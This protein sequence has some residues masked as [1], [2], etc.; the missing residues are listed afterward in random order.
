M[1]IEEYHTVHEIK[2]IETYALKGKS[3]TIGITS[4]AAIY[5]SIDV[6]RGLIRRCADI[7]VVMSQEAAK[8]ISPIL[9]EWACG[10]R[11]LHEISGMVEHI[12]LAKLCDSMAIVPATANTICKIA[13]GI[14]DTPVTLTAL[15]FI[16]VNKPL[17]VVPAMH[18]NL[19]RSS[20]VEEAIK[21]LRSM[22][23]VV[24][25]PIMEGKRLKIPNVDDIIHC[26][27]AVTLRG[28][29]LKGLKILVTAG[30]TREFLD[31]VRFIS[32]PSSGLMG[33]ALA[34]EA[35]FRG[36]QV[37]LVHGPLSNVTPPPWVKRIE[38]TTT[39]ELAEA[40]EHELKR[41][42]YDAVILAGAPVDYKFSAIFSEKIPSSQGP[43][44][45]R[46]ELTPKVSEIVRESFKGLVVGF[47]A[48]TVKDRNELIA[49][50]IEKMERYGFDITVANNVARKDIGFA[51]K[52][53]EVIIIMK[54]GKIID[55]PK[56]T[57]VEVARIIL[58]Q[59]VKLLKRKGD[60]L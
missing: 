29:D 35:Y 15:S 3:I 25:D 42:K 14:A 41:N 59:V 24:L 53:N 58:D 30:P 49:K 57:K 34:R 23:V 28:Q 26:I 46:L 20:Q 4:S 37:T 51:S 45:I 33:V 32:N 1:G 22:N 2:C 47:A 36:G 54:D 52:F 18:I 39:E 60:L 48:E 43:L 27:E 19:Y 55:V 56:T 44:T 9:F 7:H 8:F 5:K 6:V 13:N 38:I 21:K 40:V 11:V 12:A 10:H 31:P 50:A 17:I 16:G